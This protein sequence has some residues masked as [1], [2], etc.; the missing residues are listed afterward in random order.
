MLI[1]SNI[2]NIFRLY[3]YLYTINNS[4]YSNSS[5]SNSSNSTNSSNSNS[6]S[7]SN[8]DTLLFYRLSPTNEAAGG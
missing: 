4:I 2:P 5:S 6:S 7:S 3:Y 1:H 8:S